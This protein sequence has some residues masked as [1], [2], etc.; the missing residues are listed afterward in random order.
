MSK[1]FQEYDL[2]LSSKI[3]PMTRKRVPGSLKSDTRCVACTKAIVGMTG[4]L[5]VG[6]HEQMAVEILA[7]HDSSYGEQHVRKRVEFC[8]A[9]IQQQIK[10]LS[11]RGIGKGLLAVGDFSALLDI[12]EARFPNRSI[13]VQRDIGQHRMRLTVV[14]TLA[15]LEAKRYA[16]INKFL[17][18]GVTKSMWHN[19]KRD[20]LN[21]LKS[22][23]TQAARGG[24]APTLFTQGNKTFL[25]SQGDLATKMW[26]NYLECEVVEELPSYLVDGYQRHGLPYFSV[27]ESIFAVPGEYSFKRIAKSLANQLSGTNLTSEQFDELAG[28]C[29]QLPKGFTD[30]GVRDF[31]SSAI[32]LSGQTKRRQGF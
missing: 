17:G 5:L 23:T 10:G 8:E 25:V 3:S 30:R 20:L 6:V 13:S 12:V 11:A 16:L 26:P 18:Y 7:F 15:R 31:V 21:R 22:I 19:Q 1:A 29:Q 4:G 28:K 2:K 14:E 24:M 27:L 9:G 32:L